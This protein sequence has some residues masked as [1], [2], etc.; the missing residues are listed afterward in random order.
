VK[1]KRDGSQACAVQVGLQKFAM[2]LKKRK[3]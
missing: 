2:V 3:N 1:P